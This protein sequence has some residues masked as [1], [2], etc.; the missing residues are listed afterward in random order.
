MSQ[1][2][3]TPCTIACV[4]HLPPADGWQAYTRYISRLLGGTPDYWASALNGDQID[5][6][7]LKE[8]ATQYDLVLFKTFQP[9]WWQRLLGLTPARRVVE[10]ATTS[11]LI[12]RQEYRPIRSILFIVRA[13]QN[14]E[15]ALTWVKRLAGSGDVIVTLLPIVPAIPAMYRKHDRLQ[16]DLEILLTPATACGA[17]LCYIIHQLQQQHIPVRLYQSTG[18]PDRQI[19]RVVNEGVYDL[20]I[21]SAEPYGRLAR[22]FLGELVGPLLDWAKQPVLVARPMRIEPRI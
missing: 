22:W 13:D 14:D 4:Q 7:W 19:R 11:I 20:L 9:T 12:V 18:E 16:L 8:I 17:Y 21:I 5:P 1:R 2:I 15:V 10:Q 6:T 3:E